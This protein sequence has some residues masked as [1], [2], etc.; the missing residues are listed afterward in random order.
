MRTPSPWPSR[1]SLDWREESLGPR[2]LRESKS[3]DVLASTMSFRKDG[4][5]PMTSQCQSA[6]SLSS[7]DTVDAYSHSRHWRSSFN[8]HT[9]DAPPRPLARP[10]RGAHHDARTRAR[11]HEMKRV[12]YLSRD[13]EDG[14][15]REESERATT[16]VTYVVRVLKKFR[17]CEAGRFSSGQGPTG[18]RLC[19]HITLPVGAGGRAGYRWK[20]LGEPVLESQKHREESQNK[21]FDR[22]FPGGKN[23]HLQDFS[24]SVGM[25]RVA[26]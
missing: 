9:N 13:R 6:S 14:G 16:N 11:L 17:F 4:R 1:G 15:T 25:W 18:T 5:R 8:L 22:R 2:S 26:P 23:E 20:A 10:P 19:P 7:A 24:L 3:V 12:S 21:N